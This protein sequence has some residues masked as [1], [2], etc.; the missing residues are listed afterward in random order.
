MR[1]LL[2]Q[3]L[4]ALFLFSVHLAQGQ[5]L[6]DLNY[7]NRRLNEVLAD[8]E[9]KHKLRFSYA[10]D[11]LQL[12]RG[13]NIFLRQKTLDA[14]LKTMFDQNNISYA[15]FG[16]QWVLKNAPQK[17]IEKKT[18]EQP[19]KLETPIPTI[20][21]AEQTVS[22][23]IEIISLG[24]KQQTDLKLPNSF[25]KMETIPVADFQDGLALQKSKSSIFQF[26]VFGNKS[27]NAH[28]SNILALNLFWGRHAQSKGFEF[29]GIGSLLSKNMQGVQVSGIFNA[30]AVNSY[31][32]QVS[33]LL[34]ATGGKLSG[35]QLA[36]LFN[37]A[38]EV[39]GL[40]ITPGINYVKTELNGFQ[41]A[42]I[43]NL[44]ANTKEGA[45]IAGLF[46]ASKASSNVQL[47]GFYNKTKQLR[48][49]QL[50]AG[51][52]EAEESS[53]VQMGFVNRAKM[54]KGVQLGFINFAD[55][56]EGVTLGFINIVRAGGY[57][58]LEASFSESMHVLLSLKF[59]SK[60]MYQ[61]CQGGFNL[62]GKAWG[63]G[64]GMGSAFNLNKK[65]QMN[66][67]AVV[68]HIN[69]ETNWNPVLNLN[70]QLKVGFEYKLDKEF[71]LYLGPTANFMASR[72]KDKE[73]GIVGS[74]VPMYSIIDH[75]NRFDTNFRFWVGLQTGMRMRLW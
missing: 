20:T 40:Q 50:C 54:L 31:G 14:A 48:G 57:N 37:L 12:N 19:K 74:S 71:S 28:R 52:N 13:I 6:V 59:G 70:T 45:Q 44:S 49:L 9:G 56:V 35:V 34:N 25:H 11:K 32:L 41:L 38:N 47:S 15:Q 33:A 22:K 60:N 65:W 26:S 63:I 69:E 29:S 30:T 61:I 68:M 36:G 43:G 73:T 3:C 17:Q 64:W 46:N 18:I 8:L 2:T 23:E 58:K 67:D 10:P 7:S 55:T 39:K 51:I 1:L 24:Q 75:T 16:H 72:Y 66:S 42:G 27:S 21:A 4:L 62:K 53:G 5:A